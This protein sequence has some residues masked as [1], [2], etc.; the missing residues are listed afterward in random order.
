M[1]IYLDIDILYAAINTYV[2]IEIN[3]YVDIDILYDAIKTYVATLLLE[4]L[5]HFLLVIIW[6]MIS[7]AVFKNSFHAL[8]VVTFLKFEVGSFSLES[9]T[10]SKTSNLDM[11]ILACFYFYFSVRSRSLSDPAYCLP[12]FSSSFLLLYPFSSFSSFFASLIFSSLLSPFLISHLFSFFPFSL[13]SLSLN[14]FSECSN[15]KS[16]DK[17]LYFF[18]I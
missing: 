17:L 6:M 8:I 1:N 3:I 9:Q 11:L 16:I 2:N 4:L 14:Y 18:R 10:L 7:V 5:E 15:K 12:L 13:F